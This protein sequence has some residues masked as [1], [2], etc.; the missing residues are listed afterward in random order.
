M[1][2]TLEDR[3]VTELTLEAIRAVVREEMSRPASP[4]LNTAAAAVYLGSTPGTLRNWR[5]SGKGPRC[6][7][8]QDRLIR[9]HVEDL[10][11]FARGN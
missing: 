1:G 8:L 4:W 6:S 2:S 3:E 9:Y 11:S 5:A 7:V 10:D